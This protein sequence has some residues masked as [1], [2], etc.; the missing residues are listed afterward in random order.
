MER[1]VTTGWG[2]SSTVPFAAPAWVESELAAARSPDD[3]A[4][5][6]FERAAA[7][8][9]GDVDGTALTTLWWLPDTDG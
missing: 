4:V 1:T 7:E 5:R 9:D 8:A 3:A 6:I 2:A